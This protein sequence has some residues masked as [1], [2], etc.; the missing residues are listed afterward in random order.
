[1]M[2]LYNRRP[3][4]WTSTEDKQLAT[5]WNEGF[6]AGIIAEQLFNRSRCSIIARARRLG[7]PGRQPVV[8]R[9]VETIR[10]SNPTPPIVR[11]DPC[12]MCGTRGDIGCQHRE[13]A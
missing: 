10:R 4:R 2:G 3:S 8:H 12:I 13:A 1:M 9:K 7:L 11:R 5:L 6:S